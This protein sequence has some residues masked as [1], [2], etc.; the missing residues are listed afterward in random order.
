M[1]DYQLTDNPDV[2]LRT[3]NNLHGHAIVRGSS[4]WTKYEDWLKGGGIPDPSLP[5]SVPA[6]TMMLYDHENRLREIEG[7]PSLN[8]EAFI[9]LMNRS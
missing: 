7:E 3:T 2:V 9:E 5:S 4:E 8:V 1:A 6:E